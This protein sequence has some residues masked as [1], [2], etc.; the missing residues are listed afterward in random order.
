M[1]L[2]EKGIKRFDSADWA[3]SKETAGA[4]KQSLLQRTLQAE[5][6]SAAAEKPQPPPPPPAADPVAEQEAMAKAKYGSLA[7]KNHAAIARRNH[8]MKRFDSADWMMSKGGDAAPKS[9]LSRTLEGEAA[10]SVRTQDPVKRP[11][12]RLETTML[13]LTLNH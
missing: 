10:A 4:P 5:A 3:M 9:L 11:S 1:D 6:A 12:S 8:G 7:P 13:S 2:K